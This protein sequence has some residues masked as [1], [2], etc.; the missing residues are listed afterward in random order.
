[1]RS[2]HFV[3]LGVLVVLAFILFNGKVEGL[4]GLNCA[5]CT[6]ISSAHIPVPVGKCPD[7]P[8]LYKTD[9]AGSNCFGW[10]PYSNQYK[11]DKGGTNCIMYP[12]GYCDENPERPK[13]DEEGSNCIDGK[14]DYKLCPDNDALKTFEGATNCFG[15]CP[16]S[17]KQQRKVYKWPW[18][19]CPAL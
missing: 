14:F 17:E 2:F 4:T 16:T 9:E 1:M 15:W 13:L 11:T 19:Q 7:N 12:W 6:P 8:L 10:C 3:A 5:N 18:E